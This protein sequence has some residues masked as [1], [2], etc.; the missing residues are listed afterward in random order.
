MD[1]Y[2][3]MK[4]TASQLASPHA[5]RTRARCQLFRV[6]LN[7]SVVKSHHPLRRNIPQTVRQNA[8]VTLPT[9][10]VDPATWLSGKPAIVP[11][12]VASSELCTALIQ[13]EECS[14]NIVWRP[15]RDLSVSILK[16]FYFYNKGDKSIKI[17]C[18]PTS[19]DAKQYFTKVCT[20]V[21][22]FMLRDRTLNHQ[23]LFQSIVPWLCWQFVFWSKS[24][25]FLQYCL[26]I[27]DC[28]IYGT[29]PDVP[30]AS[31][32]PGLWS[33]EECGAKCLELPNCLQWY[34]SIS[35]QH[36]HTYDTI[37]LPTALNTTSAIIGPRGCPGVYKNHL[38]FLTVLY[39]WMYTWITGV[40]I[41]HTVSEILLSEVCRK[42]YWKNI[43]FFSPP[44]MYSLET[45]WTM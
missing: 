32:R 30:Q 14:C 35:E 38:K 12:S 29:L 8:L 42:K 41:G 22:L 10:A 45:R 20:V 4:R 7:V 11:V 18:T 39:V 36:C 27:P 1:K 25:K 43:P 23:R 34:W 6:V 33:W 31:L 9:T 5:K 13:K 44:F 24:L 3:I 28:T 2:G 19:R 17:I 16:N 40:T 37:I 15:L 26:G 21:E